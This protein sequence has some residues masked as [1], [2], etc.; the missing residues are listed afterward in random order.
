MPVRITL[1]NVL[2][3]T[4]PTDGWQ[5]RYRVKGTLGAYITATGSPFTALPIIFNTTDAAGT[6]YEGFIK[7]DCG[8][9]ESVDFAWVTPCVCP[10]TYSVAAAGTYCQKIE[11]IGATITNSGYCLAASVN[12]AYSGYESRVYTIGVVN[13][14]L[15]LPPGSVGEHIVGIATAT[16][17][18][19][20]PLANTTAGPLNREGIWID[21]DC[22]GSTNSLAG[23]VQTTISFMF[24]NLDVARVIYIGIG[25]DNQF[26][27]IVNG[28][29]IVDSGT[30]TDTPFKIWHI[31][32]VT[33]LPGINYFNAI[34]TGD[35][36]VNDSIG[37]V[38]YNN[39]AGQIL[40]AN[41]DG[42]L[43][44]LFK[45]S[46]LRNTTF[47]VATCPSGYSLDSS[48]GSGSYQCKRTLTSICNGL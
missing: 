16:P 19:S 35:G 4:V 7:N 42:A 31:I 47:D 13:A 37:M 14:D 33:I 48:G 39:T 43:N 22:N 8:A 27:L 36:S 1:S 24:N 18:W 11:T 44:I 5:I 26:Q 28:A 41:S 15:I 10:A 40:T 25:A 46:N 3:A 34:G 45:T 30:G 20:N 21:S 23:G 29:L 17:Q 32:P 12:G 6:L 38:G 2:P 9:I